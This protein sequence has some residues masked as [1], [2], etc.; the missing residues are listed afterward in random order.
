MF[1]GCA[2]LGRL[3]KEEG[4]SLSTGPL[5][6]SVELIKHIVAAVTDQLRF[7]IRTTAYRWHLRWATNY[8]ALSVT[9]AVVFVLSISRTHESLIDKEE[10]LRLAEEIGR[11]LQP[12]P[13][14]HFHR[15]IRLL[16]NL[17]A[18]RSHSEI[19]GQAQPEL[20]INQLPDATA[21]H[22]PP[23]LSIETLLSG[24][25]Q[26]PDWML[27]PSSITS[28]GFPGDGNMALPEQDLST[29]HDFTFPV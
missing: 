14:P 2:I 19:E 15:L 22:I 8:T 12:Y 18:N 10:T 25:L 23:D 5:Q 3:Q 27:D 16:I 21:D 9:F 4:S 17:T 28:V 26:D 1:T 29:V 11:I 6:G 20:G 13:H 24:H 7:I